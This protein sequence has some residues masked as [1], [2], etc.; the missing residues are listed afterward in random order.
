MQRRPTLRRTASNSPAWRR[1]LSSKSWIGVVR[2]GHWCCW[3]NLDA[4]RFD[5]FAPANHDVFLSNEADVLR[6][7]NA[8][9]ANLPPMN[10]V[11]LH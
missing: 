11:R 5:G 4:H 3:Q 7:M 8:F 1:M 9:I 10:A 6:E 2:A